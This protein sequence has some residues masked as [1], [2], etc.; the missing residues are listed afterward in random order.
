MPLAFRDWSGQGGLREK[1]L[2]LVA[3]TRERRSKRLQR[4]Q[5]ARMPASRFVPFLGRIIFLHH[6]GNVGGSGD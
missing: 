4:G 6:Q 2:K 3:L 5:E 1:F